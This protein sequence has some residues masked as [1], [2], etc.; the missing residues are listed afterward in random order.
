MMPSGHVSRFTVFLAKETTPYQ[1]PELQK[2]QKTPSL[3]V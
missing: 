2:K 3:I 1:P